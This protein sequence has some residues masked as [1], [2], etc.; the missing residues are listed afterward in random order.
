LRCCLTCIATASEAMAPGRRFAALLGPEQPGFHTEFTE[1][2]EG[3]NGKKKF[4]LRALRE[5]RVKSW[6]PAVG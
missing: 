3:Q 4:S 1:N 6:S 2:T 5:L